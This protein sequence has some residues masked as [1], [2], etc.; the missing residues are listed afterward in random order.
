MINS[1]RVVVA[2]GEQ[3]QVSG[4]WWWSDCAWLRNEKNWKCRLSSSYWWGIETDNLAFW[5]SNL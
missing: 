2:F 1:S 5:N 3:F 4:G